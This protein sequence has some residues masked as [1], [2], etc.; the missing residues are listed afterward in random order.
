MGDRSN[1]L[2]G[3]EI[4]EKLISFINAMDD[5][6]VIAFSQMLDH[7]CTLQSPSELADYLRSR[8]LS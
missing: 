7:L 5:A 1:K 2:S 4:R 6:Q 3:P 8:G